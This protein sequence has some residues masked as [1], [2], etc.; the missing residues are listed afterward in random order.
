[1]SHWSLDDIGSL[2]TTGCAE[3]LINLSNVVT[4]NIES[5]LYRA[6][7][8]S[9]SQHLL[10]SM[11]NAFYNDNF[12]SGSWSNISVSEI[13]VEFSSFSL[14]PWIQFDAVTF[15]LPVTVEAMQ[16]WA[17]EVPS[18][19]NS[20]TSDGDY[21]IDV[22]SRTMGNEHGFIYTSPSSG[23]YDVV[24]LRR[25]CVT[26]ENGSTQDMQSLYEDCKFHSESSVLIFS[27]AN[28]IWMD[29]IKLFNGS[30]INGSTTIINYD[31]ISYNGDNYSFGMKNPRKIYSLTPGKLS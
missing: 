23:F 3:V 24:E 31:N 30:R 26:E 9:S 6:M 21:Y 4:S 1:M 11:Q 22:S 29:E 25:L 8:I 13:T 15:E 2:F 19:Y 12:T 7:D 14:S 5:E 20:S 27:L 10:D 18:F 17:N 28:H 16:A